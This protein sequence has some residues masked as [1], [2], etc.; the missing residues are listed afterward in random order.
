MKYTHL[1]MLP[2]QAFQKSANGSIRP[3]GGSGGGSSNNGAPTQTNVTQT[4]IPQYAQPYVESMLG[5]TQQQ[6]FNT[7]QTGGTP[8]YYQTTPGV[9]GANDSQQWVPGTPGTT[10]ITGIKGYTPY[11]AN[12]SDYVAGFSPLQQ[13]AFNQ[14]QNMQVAPQI[15]QATGIANQASQGAMDTAAP[16][17]GYGSMGAGYG[18]QGSQIGRGGIGVGLAGMQ[19]GMSYGQNATD[20]NAVAAYMNPYL[21]A[22][23]APQQQL[24][25]QQ[26]GI[27][28]AQNQGQ[29]TQQGAFGGGRQAIMQGLNQQNQ[30]LAT[31]QL[32]SQGYNNAYNIAN[33]NMQAASQLGMQGA[34]VGLQG[35]NT[36]LAGTA[37]GMQGAQTG[38]QG[39]AGAQAG[40]GLG[41]Q[42]ANT[43]G[44]L[45]TNQYN[46]EMGINQAQLQAGSL[47]QQ[48]Q[49]NIINQGI[50]N[51]NTAQQYPQQQLSFMNSMLRGLPMSTSTTQQYAAPPSLTS[52]AAGLGLAGA[53]AYQL[54]KAEGGMIK[55]KKFAAGGI[56]SGVPAGKL[57]SMLGRLS[58]QQLQQKTQV[59]QNDPDTAAAAMG[60]EAFRQQMR[61]PGIGAAPAP[62]MAAMAGGGIVAFADGGEADDEGE[63][64]VSADAA[65]E[66]KKA[67]TPNI[68]D[69]ISARKEQTGEFTGGKDY[70][71]KLEGMLAAGGGDKDKQSAMRFMQAGLGILGGA[72]PYAG[73]NIGKGAEPAVQGAMQDV[74]DQ[75]KQ[76][77]EI[78]KAQYDVSK[79]D[80][81][82]QVD[83]VKGAH[84]DY[85]KQVDRLMHL[86]MSETQA[87]ATIQSAQIHAGATLGA[88]KEHTAASKAAA[89]LAHTKAVEIENMKENNAQPNR[90]YKAGV[91]A[92]V[93]ENNREPTA[94][95]KLAIRKDAIANSGPYA[96]INQQKVDLAT[97]KADPELR[98]LGIELL[99]ADET[100]T[101]KVMDK[102]TA[103]KKE[104]AA[105]AAGKKPTNT[106]TNTPPKVGTIQNGYEFTGGNPSDKK[107][108]KRVE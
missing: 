77:M 102:I 46:Q 24:L 91:E 78:A 85:N 26:F 47:Q 25:N 108:W 66:V 23:L 56:A 35:L 73:V 29:A 48:Q 22:S 39:V 28:N 95:E 31:N 16:A 3:Q 21:Q 30:D 6:L 34:G 69:L 58:D 17:M 12:P 20:P 84:E 57:D 72:S 18:Q 62:S 13:Q 1:N 97:E 38:L 2:E 89:E 67:G 15:G 60:Q 79:M 96:G 100:E 93:A 65:D 99:G 64:T 74:K 94:Q 9:D 75:Q 42:G 43:L 107:N 52:Q 49:Q 81:Q 68:V 101:V 70:L 32:V 40:Y 44:Q 41:L 92:F 8:G 11:S 61:N 106:L 10:E 14:I 71:G 98:K 105:E 7:Q 54:L 53:G 80:Y 104:L 63:M 55:E 59:P 51:Y 27:Q 103:R 88:A 86:G 4:N 36:A 19:A 50:Q 37:Q 5:A 33:Q 90:L 83:I 76:Q 82:T 87:K 45:G